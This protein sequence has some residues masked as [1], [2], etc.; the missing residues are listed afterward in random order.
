MGI[1]VKINFYKNTQDYLLCIRLC[2]SII[3]PFI[4]SYLHAMNKQTILLSIFTFF[5]WQVTVQ[6]QI[7]TTIAGGGTSGI[8]DGGQAI[9]CELNNPIGIVDAA[10]NIYIGDRNHH[11]IRKISTT[12]VITT[13]AGTGTAGFSGD[14]GPATDAKITSPYGVAVDNSGNVYFAE[15]TTNGRIRK[16]SAAGI[17]TTVAGGGTGGLGDGGPATDATV[18]T[19]S[20]TVDASNNLYI[21]DG[22]NH[23]VRKVDAAG[24]ITTIAGGGTALG[25]GGPATAAKMNLPYAITIDVVG[26]IY[27]T[28]DYGARVRKITPSGIITTVAGTGLSGYNGDG[29]SATEAKLNRPTGV[30]VDAAGNI[31]I[32]DAHN[33]R[34]R[35]VDTDGKISTIAGTGMAGL[36]GDGGNATDAQLKTP[37]GVAIGNAG[38]LYISDFG[39]NRIR[40]VSNVVTVISVN[41]T[42]TAIIT[43]PNP[44]NGNFT[45]DISSGY[46]DDCTLVVTDILGRK[47]YQVDRLRGQHIGVHLD[48]P[49]GIYVLTVSSPGGI[50][51]TK[52]IEIIK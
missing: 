23:R 24:I 50:A 29:I 32:G 41:R 21:A 22:A 49:P 52:K 26:N 17:I 42:Q 36:M 31:Y 38:N 5:L 12:G 44:S 19:A 10:G 51:A 9:D 1:Y 18:G 2:I 6:A 3:L 14:G 4:I 47:V 7:I 46:S 48:V 13:I 25:D 39:N 35:R 15:G 30:A 33:H 43:Y 20:V 45:V 34:I 28:E 8:G 16:I 27:V 40:S 11:R 37:T